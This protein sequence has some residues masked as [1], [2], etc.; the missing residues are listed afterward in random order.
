MRLIGFIFLVS[1]KRVRDD[2]EIGIFLYG[3]TKRTAAFSRIDQ[4][5]DLISTFDPE[6]YQQIRKDVKKILIFP[7]PP[8]AA[9]WIG[10]LQMCV[11]DNEYFFRADISPAEIAGTIVHEATHAHL[12]R[13]DMK[14]IEESRARIE[15][16]CTESQIAFAK[17]LPEPGRTLEIAEWQMKLP[18][19]YWHN[20]EFQNRNL[21]ALADLGKTSW[22]ARRVHSL[23]KWVIAKRSSKL[24]RKGGLPGK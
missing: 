2:F 12:E 1:R 7:T 18:E 16:I 19:N 17:R 4:A 3:K 6:R 21:E 15:R 23:M 10:T 24:K 8:D 14:Y 5:L 11:I 22:F 9:Q 13:L 20:D